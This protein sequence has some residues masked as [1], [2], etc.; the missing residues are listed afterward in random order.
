MQC[1][2]END[3]EGMSYRAW[4]ERWGL[5]A[6]AVHWHMKKG[7]CHLH[8]NIPKDHPL[9]QTYQAMIQRCYNPKEPNYPNWGGR[10]IRICGRWFYSFQNFVDDMGERPEGH[11]LDRI[12]VNGDYS[13]E[14]CRWA[15]W[16]AQHNNR[17]NNVAESDKQAA[18]ELRAKGLSLRAIAKQLNLSYGTVSIACKS[19]HKTP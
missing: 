3:L 11:T 9:K 13:P 15:S 10:S 5:K 6:T 18:R 8:S 16:K 1:K 14:N 4:A 7:Y 2:T 17:R 12:D 19:D